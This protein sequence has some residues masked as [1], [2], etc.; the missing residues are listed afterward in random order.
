ME[1]SIYNYVFV[2]TCNDYPSPNRCLDPESHK[3]EAQ[4]SGPKAESLLGKT[5]VTFLPLNPC[6][7]E[8]ESSPVQ[9]Q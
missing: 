8:E 7:D 3:E 2:S 4:I 5:W 9:Q 1:R 6:L